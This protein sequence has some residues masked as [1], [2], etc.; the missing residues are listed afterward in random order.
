MPAYLSDRSRAARSFGLALVA[1]A[2]IGCAQLAGLE[3]YDPPAPPAAE[4]GGPGSPNASAG[5]GGSIGSAGSGAGGEAHGMGG[6][7]GVAGGASY[8]PPPS[9]G[10]SLPGAGLDCGAS[11]TED[12]CASSLVDAGSYQCLPPPNEPTPVEPFR[13][14]NFEV[15]VG[16]FEVFARAAIEGWRPRQGEGRH[17]AAANFSDDDLGWKPEWNV[18]LPSGARENDWEAHVGSCDFSTWT[19]SSP[20]RAWLPINCVTYFHAMAYCIWDG[21]YLPSALELSYAAQGG[22]QRMYPWG[23]E[24]IDPQRAAYFDWSEESPQAVGSLPLGNGR[25]GHSDQVGN[26]WEWTSYNS[27]NGGDCADCDCDN[28]EPDLMHGRSF[29]GS[30]DARADEAVATSYQRVELEKGVYLRDRGIRCGRAP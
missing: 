29:G 27:K 11:K 4:G 8:A 16:R 21:G 12:C 19:V 23:N 3:D 15:T 1:L 13:L 9:C 18:H 26:V 14:D 24:P 20:E 7:P 25:W 5:Q 22:E 6:R 28:F 2:I 10:Q 17:P 30:Y